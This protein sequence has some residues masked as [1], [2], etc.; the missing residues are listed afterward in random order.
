MAKQ[1]RTRG[2]K[3]SQKQGAARNGGRGNTGRHNSNSRNNMGE[4]RI[5]GGDFRGRKLPVLDAEGLR[6]TSDRV[7]ETVFNWLQFDI[8]GAH[9]LDVFAGSG[10]LSFEAI[11]R[12]AKSVTLLELN[13]ANAQQLKNNAATLKA[14]QAN[15]CQTDSLQWL[16]Q[17]AQQVFDV[18]FLDPPFH[19]GMMQEAVDLLFKNGYIAEHSLIYVEQEKGLE[20]PTLAN[21]WELKKDKKT[22]QV[23]FGLVKFVD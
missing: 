13:T 21:G 9:C 19:K 6:P 1:N 5:I 23:Q 22:S 11:S 3:P 17:P 2:A 20:W 14:Q 7:R 18:V 8:A 15:I 12:G 16:Q 4:L 10:A